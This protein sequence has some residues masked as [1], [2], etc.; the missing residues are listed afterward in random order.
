MSQILV[1]TFHT[2]HAHAHIT[3]VHTYICTWL[4]TR[5]DVYDSD[6]HIID[7]HTL[8]TYMHTYIC[9]WLGTRTDVYDSDEHI[10]DVKYSDH[11]PTAVQILL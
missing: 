6:E 10:I 1:I 7:I 4:G 2:A 11:R 8:H 5:N 9:T 3:Y